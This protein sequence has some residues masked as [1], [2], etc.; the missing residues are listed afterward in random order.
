MAI[1]PWT[2]ALLVGCLPQWS[3]A[4]GRDKL[5]YSKV[6]K[7]IFGPKRHEVTNYLGEMHNE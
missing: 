7:K 2:S 5:Q 4:D 3:P 6:L 1:F